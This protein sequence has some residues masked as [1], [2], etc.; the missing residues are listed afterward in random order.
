M[1]M[2]TMSRIATGDEKSRMTGTAKATHPEGDDRRTDVYHDALKGRLA[3][4][5]EVPLL[6][7][8]LLRA[9]VARDIAIDNM[10]QGICVFTAEK[11]LAFCNRRYAEIYRLDPEQIVHGTTLSEINTRRVAAGTSHVDAEH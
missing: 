6:S 2:P 4:Y 3:P 7:L 8:D 1:R 10:P 5:S 9:M 11:K